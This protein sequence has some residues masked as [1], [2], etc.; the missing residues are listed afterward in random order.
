MKYLNEYHEYI[1][2]TNK[3]N[4]NVKKYL[5][6]DEPNLYGTILGFKR[7]WRANKPINDDYYSF[8][9]YFDHSTAR[10]E[11]YLINLGVKKPIELV[12]INEDRDPDLHLDQEIEGKIIRPVYNN[13]FNLPDNYLPHNL[14]DGKLNNTFFSI[15]IF[16]MFRDYLSGGFSYKNPNINRIIK[17]TEPLFLR[18][19]DVHLK[20]GSLNYSDLKNRNQIDPSASLFMFERKE[21]IKYEKNQY[22]VIKFPKLFPNNAINKLLMNYGYKV[23]FYDPNNVPLVIKDLK[24]LINSRSYAHHTHLE[25]GI[26]NFNLVIAKKIYDINNNINRKNKNSS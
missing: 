2:N 18:K 17:S 22:K 15:F 16:E 14:H 24:K 26:E 7:G 1:A 21:I 4:D 11:R 6:G 10:I 8:L 13:K 3:W 20:S 5:I 19:N 23:E 25:R 12:R 9:I